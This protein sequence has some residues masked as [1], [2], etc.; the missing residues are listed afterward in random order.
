M[1]RAWSWCVRNRLWLVSV[2]ISVASAPGD[3]GYLD[4]FLPFVFAYAV[5]FGVDAAT[6]LIGYAF[7]SVWRDGRSSKTRKWIASLLVPLHF[8]MFYFAVVFAH[9]QFQ[10]LQPQ[11]LPLLLWSL[12]AFAPAALTGL[13]IAQGVTETTAKKPKSDTEP[14]K[15][16]PRHRATIAEWREIYPNLNGDRADLT[17]DCVNDLL[18]SR[19]FE[20]LPASTARGWAKEA[21]EG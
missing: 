11:E 8:G 1:T 12:A 15:P 6:E 10:L 17:A 3:G 18:W 13:G 14:A 7:V 20:R 4:R 2:F 21:R 9:R 19:G 5:N 16:A